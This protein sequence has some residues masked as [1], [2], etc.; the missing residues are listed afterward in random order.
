[1]EECEILKGSAEFDTGCYEL[2]IVGS[3]LRE[4]GKQSPMVYIKTEVENISYLE[5]NG[6][7]YVFIYKVI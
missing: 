5:Y 2:D 7:F 3:Y 4:S 1:M 6:Q